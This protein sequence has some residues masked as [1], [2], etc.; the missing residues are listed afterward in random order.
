MDEKDMSFGQYLKYK[1]N[2]R[3]ITL[4]AFAEQVGVAASYISDIEKGNRN[5][6]EKYFDKII[7]VLGLADDAL[8]M[9]YDLVGKA[10][11]GVAPDLNEYICN[12][13]VARV[14]LRRARDKDI[15]DELWED[16]IKRIDSE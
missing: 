8:N 1:R 9:F 6:P 11:A 13:E 14:A 16:F 3:G 5:P 15:D 12:T 10:H 7:E 2:E 4:R